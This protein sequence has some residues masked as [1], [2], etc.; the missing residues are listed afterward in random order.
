VVQGEQPTEEFFSGGG[1]DS[2]AEAV[3]F[4]EGFDFV[5]VMLQREI[6]PSV[7]I[8]DGEVEFDVE[9]AQFE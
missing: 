6:L 8:A 3:V 4:G 2:V 1:A 7:G 5:E 9:S